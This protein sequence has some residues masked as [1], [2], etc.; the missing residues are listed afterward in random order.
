MRP[1]RKGS[2]IPGLPAQFLLLASESNLADIN[3]SIYVRQNV[4]LNH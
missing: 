4:F 3:N 1:S 2:G